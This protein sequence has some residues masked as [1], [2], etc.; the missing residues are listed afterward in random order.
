MGY[1]DI[2]YILFVYFYLDY[3][4]SGREIFEEP[5]VQFIECKQLDLN[6]QLSGLPQEQLISSAK[7]NTKSTQKKSFL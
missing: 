1:L 5:T 2:L 6:N 3:L 4:I 7:F